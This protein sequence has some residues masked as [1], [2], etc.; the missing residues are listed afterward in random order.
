MFQ[1]DE[2]ATEKHCKNCGSDRFEP[3]DLIYDR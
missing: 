3:V 2:A 1:R